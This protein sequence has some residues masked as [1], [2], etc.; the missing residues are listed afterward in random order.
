M[1]SGGSQE[2]VLKEIVRNEA[3]RDIVLG[4]WGSQ[5]RSDGS[6]AK[7]KQK[8]VYGSATH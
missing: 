3:A 2:R 7:E 1:E 5:L 8:E 4:R 6:F